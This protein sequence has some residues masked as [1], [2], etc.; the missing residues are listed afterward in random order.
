MLKRW[1]KTG[2]SIWC[3]LTVRAVVKICAGGMLVCFLC[4]CEKELMMEKKSG[5]SFT[6]RWTVKDSKGGAVLCPY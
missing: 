3:H 4:S 1:V 2:I 6:D 5:L